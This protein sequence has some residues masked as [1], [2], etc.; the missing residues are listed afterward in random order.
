VRAC[1]VDSPDAAAAAIEV[2]SCASQTT[3][4]AVHCWP[5]QRCELCE[6]KQVLCACRSGTSG[7]KTCWWLG[8]VCLA[9][10]HGLM[11][12]RR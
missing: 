2:R 1:T 3:A 4:V 11:L 6:G 12:L 9:R 8:T 10:I 5:M 7:L